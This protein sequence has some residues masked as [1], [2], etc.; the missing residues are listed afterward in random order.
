MEVGVCNPV[1][2]Q[3]SSKKELIIYIFLFMCAESLYL[4]VWVS[5]RPC[6]NVSVDV[7]ECFKTHTAQS[8][9]AKNSLL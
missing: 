8:L 1:Q 2:T 3:N 6:V 5:G 7:Y 9:K 4:S